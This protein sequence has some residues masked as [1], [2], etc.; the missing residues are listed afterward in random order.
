MTASEPGPPESTELREGLTVNL[1]DRWDV[2]NETSKENITLGELM[3]G[4][5]SQTKL[6][7][8][9]VM[10]G[11]K[12]LFFYALMSAPGKEQDREKKMKEK[13]RDLLDLDNPVEEEYS[14][15]TV[16]FAKNK[17]DKDILKGVPPVRVRFIAK[18]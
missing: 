18:Q 10:R 17:E 8:R 15:L 13:M 14:D 12:P 3:S 6:H 4:L 7:V 5:E 2:F 9:D 11:N 1:W 16:T